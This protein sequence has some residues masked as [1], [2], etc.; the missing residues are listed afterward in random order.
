VASSSS[1]ITSLSRSPSAAFDDADPD[2]DYVPSGVAIS[3]RKRSTSPNPSLQSTITSTRMSVQSNGP[4][5]APPPKRQRAAPSGPIS[6]KDWV[7]PDVTGLNKR[8]ARLVKNRAA[9]FLSRQRKREEFEAMEACVSLSFQKISAFHYGRQLFWPTAISSL[10]SPHADCWLWFILCA[11]YV[12][13]FVAEW[14]PHIRRMSTLFLG[15]LSL[16]LQCSLNLAMDGRQFIGQNS[17]VQALEAEN[18]RLRQKAQQSS[19]SPFCSATSSSAATPSANSFNSDAPA[20]LSS[21]Q[22]SFV[23]LHQQQQQLRAQLADSQKREE[24]LA[25]Q[26]RDAQAS[27]VRQQHRSPQHHQH[28]TSHWPTVG[29]AP[30]PTVVKTEAMDEDERPLCQQPAPLSVP[31]QDSSDE[32]SDDEDDVLAARRKGRKEK[33]Q[34]VVREKGSGSVAFMVLL[35]SLSL[36]SGGQNRGNTDATKNP[37]QFSFKL[38]TNSGG[39]APAFDFRMQQPQQSQPEQ[40]QRRQNE[41]NEH[42]VQGATKRWTTLDAL[43]DEFNYFDRQHH[44]MPS[45]TFDVSSSR[46][47][48]SG[49]GGLGLELGLGLDDG[50]GNAGYSFGIS[51]TMAYPTLNALGSPL[52]ITP[53]ALP[54]ATSASS[55]STPFSRHRA[56]SPS[57]TSSSGAS[58]VTSAFNRQV[59]VS[60]ST[61]PSSLSRQGDGVS[62][63][64][65]LANGEDDDDLSSTGAGTFGGSEKTVTVHVRKVPSSASSSFWS[66]SSPNGKNTILLEL[67]TSSA[68]SGPN[69]SS[70]ELEALNADFEALLGNGLAIP[71]E[72]GDAA[73]Q[74]QAQWRLALAPR[75]AI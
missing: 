43:D 10:L 24:A 33:E 70:D 9:A 30:E 2:S 66:S 71:G 37:S 65:K 14:F 28:V 49:F 53:S 19:P 67:T 31:S 59:E 51:D 25:A 38:P 39:G 48:D 73:A 42:A 17:R 60:V 72:L 32:D 50:F 16:F 3:S 27:L 5:S 55:T 35:F 45:S 62:F 29:E 63:D 7:P 52:S 47:F 23:E 36:L 58:T 46:S 26:L 4:S 20:S 69:G 61:S 41:E 22:P 54:P 18:A 57:A 40:P 12:R 21:T 34:L 74:S 13:T 75:D 1:P 11:C 64:L 68:S 8:E 56:M 15:T 6:T 44:V